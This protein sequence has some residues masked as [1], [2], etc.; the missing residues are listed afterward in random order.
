MA[1][2]SRQDQ[3]I[4]KGAPLIFLTLFMTYAYFWQARCWNSATRLMLTYALADRGT[5]SIDGLENQTRDRAYV[6][7]RYYCDKPPGQSLFALPWYGAVKVLGVR[8]PLGQPPISYW[9]PDYFVTVPTS[10]LVTALLGVEIY[11]LA[12]WFGCRPWPAVV[13]ALS[14]G[15]STPAFTY[16]T[17]FYGHQTAAF[18]AFSSYLLLVQSART[19]GWSRYRMFAAGFLAGYAVVTEYTMMPVAVG[20]SAYAVYIRPSLRML[21]PFGSALL[22]CAALLLSYHAVVFGG[23]FQLGYFHETETQFQEIYSSSRSFG[24]KPPTFMAASDILLS[25]RGLFLFAPATLVAIPGIVLLM[26]RR[27]WSVAAMVVWS[28]GSI[29]LINA[30]HPT[31]TGGYAT[32]PRYILP[33]VPFLFVAIAYAASISPRCIGRVVGVLSLLGFIVVAGSTAYGGRLPDIGMPGGENPFFELVLPALRN[34]HFDRNLGKLFLA[35]W[36]ADLP[37]RFRWVAFIPLL[38]FLALMITGLRRASHH[39]ACDARSAK[40]SSCQF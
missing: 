22:L 17:L 7:G 13:T 31:W 18:C 28:F 3:R 6:A 37:M 14:Y 27:R 23:P 15:L 11:V 40:A 12:L 30:S 33:A 26:W 2:G 35:P 5:L 36:W 19:N 21:A 20:L 29:Y 9:W 10:G 39:R 25:R 34:G 16:A 24:L 32:G 4:R 8:H 1:E 38:T